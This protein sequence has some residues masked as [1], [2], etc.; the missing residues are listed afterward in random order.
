LR[1]PARVAHP[2]RGEWYAS[3]PGR[4]SG[5]GVCDFQLLAQPAP[6]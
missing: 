2:P 3:F 6:Q 4:R 5:R 1:A